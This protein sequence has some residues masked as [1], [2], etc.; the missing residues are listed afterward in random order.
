MKFTKLQACRFVVA[1]EF[2]Y[3]IFIPV[4]SSIYP[5]KTHLAYIVYVHK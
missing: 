3:G 1:T 2:T 4:Y 5:H